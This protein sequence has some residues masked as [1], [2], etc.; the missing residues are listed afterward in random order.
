MRSVGIGFHSIW[1]VSAVCFYLL[2]Y[3]HES[4]CMM[5]FSS[6][7]HDLFVPYF[8][9]PFGMNLSSRLYS[10]LAHFLHGGCSLF[11]LPFLLSTGYKSVF[12][13]KKN[14]NIDW[15]RGKYINWVWWAVIDWNSTWKMYV[16][17]RWNQTLSIHPFHPIHGHS[18]VL[19]TVQRNNDKDQT[20]KRTHNLE[21][22]GDNPVQPHLRT[23]LP[24]LK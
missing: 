1:H 14:N 20:S 15:Q 7:S 10:I 5:Q 11:F 17:S 21:I 9:Y 6:L 19:L 4:S 23:K 2:S 18:L 13:L 3:V 22:H 12:F 8:V 24:F 16:I